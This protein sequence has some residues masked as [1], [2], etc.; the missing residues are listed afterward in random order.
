MLAKTYQCHV[1]KE[2]ISSMEYFG[3]YGAGSFSRCIYEMIRK[4][5]NL[6]KLDMQNVFFI[7]DDYNGG[8]F[9]GHRLISFDKFCMFKGK[10]SALIAIADPKIRIKLTRKL[11]KHQIHRFSLIAENFTNFQNVSIGNGSVICDRFIATCDI[12]IGDG[13]HGNVGGIIEH[14]CLIGDFVTFS[15]GVICNGN[16]TIGDNVFVGSG[17]VIRNGTKERPLK[18]GRN[19]V[20]GMGAVVTKDVKS[21]TTVV[22]NPAKVVR[23]D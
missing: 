23:K 14:D 2:K 7:D 9:L 15:P 22:G 16:V 4:K 10:K 3:I 13:F 11:E 6:E 1:S 18:I 8:E 19:A 5:V 17:A 12:K 20:I 21:N